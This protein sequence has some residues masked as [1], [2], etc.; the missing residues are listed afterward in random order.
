MITPG[1]KF[2]QEIEETYML[3]AAERI[4]NTPMHERGVA[5]NEESA[6][7]KPTAFRAAHRLS[8]KCSVQASRTGEG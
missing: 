7:V 4:L 2:A 1:K 3:Q 5:A 8:G 6:I